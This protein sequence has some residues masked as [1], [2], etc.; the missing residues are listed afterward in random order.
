MTLSHFRTQIRCA[1]SEIRICSS[2]DAPLGLL[3]GSWGALSFA[4]G[5]LM[6]P[7]PIISPML[8]SGHR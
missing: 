1:A 8:I 7:H 5:M 2:F 4:P 3:L 6:L